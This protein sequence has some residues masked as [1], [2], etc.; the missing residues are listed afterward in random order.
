[1]P[2]EIEAPDM[3]KSIWKRR[4]IT[5]LTVD[6]YITEG[7][8]A[9]SPWLEIPAPRWRTKEFAVYLALVCTVP[10]YMAYVPIR[11]SYPETNPQYP[12]FAHRLVPGWLNGRLRDDS[13]F[14][15][16]LF[17]EYLPLIGALIGAYT[18]LSW[19]VRGA[20]R[21]FRCS[22]AQQH[23]ARRLFCGAMG[24]ACISALHGTN[25][26]KLLALALGNFFLTRIGTKMPPWA[27]STLVWT[28]NC[29]MLF[30]V[31]YLQG[32]PYEHIAPGWA[33]MVG[34]HAHTGRLP[35]SALALVH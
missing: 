14:Q 1:M 5:L 2:L 11:L 33:W 16:R 19:S 6:P 30:L 8:E 13:D 9:P 20:L 7:P 24:T 21:A 3:P 18:L 34:R 12:N 4:G 22:A 23:A 15:Y 32:V 35:G 10:L 29:A 28:Y 27:A 26:L 31:H 25:A 17:R